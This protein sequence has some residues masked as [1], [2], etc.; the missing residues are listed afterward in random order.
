MI[1][2]HINNLSLSLFLEAH[3]LV[4]NKYRILSHH[5]NLLLPQLI[6][7]LQID[8]PSC[9]IISIVSCA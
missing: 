5:K 9:M 2:G 8:V 4:F 3:E 1:L 6:A 7:S